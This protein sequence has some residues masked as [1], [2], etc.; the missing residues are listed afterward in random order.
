MAGWLKWD[1]DEAACAVSSLDA[2][3]SEVSGDSVTSPKGCGWSASSA[4]KVVSNLQSR[5]SS[6][7]SSIPTMS[8]NL[9]AAD[10]SMGAADSHSAST[11]PSPG[12]CFPTSA[13]SGAPTLPAQNPSPQYNPFP[14]YPWGGDN[15][16]PQYPWGGGK[17]E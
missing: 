8:T 4:S 9:S 13:F 6:L 10:K 16:F 12:M 15:P 2:A 14:Q 1:Y 11:A 3:K 17:A 7:Q 5:L